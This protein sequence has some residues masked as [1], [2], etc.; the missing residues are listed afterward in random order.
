MK[1]PLSHAIIFVFVVNV[2]KTRKHSLCNIY[3]TSKI[4]INAIDSFEKSV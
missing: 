4:V 1:S 3:K 2:F